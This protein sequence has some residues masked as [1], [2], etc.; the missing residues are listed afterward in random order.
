MRTRPTQ[1]K[2]C[3]TSLKKTLREKLSDWLFTQATGLMGV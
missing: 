1:D 2:P 3:V